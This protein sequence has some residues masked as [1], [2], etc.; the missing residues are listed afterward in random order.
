MRL[1]ARH[2]SQNLRY[3]VRFCNS[4]RKA[5]DHRTRQTELCPQGRGG[6]DVDANSV[7][8]SARE[9]G[10]KSVVV[11]SARSTE[12]AGSTTSRS[13][14]VR[15]WPRLPRPGR[16]CAMVAAR[17]YGFLPGRRSSAACCALKSRRP[18]NRTPTVRRI[19]RRV[20]VSL[21]SPPAGFPPPNLPDPNN[22]IIPLTTQGSRG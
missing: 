4:S 16:L 2:Q 18:L 3:F 22:R 17:S 14:R 19:I 6:G 5:S 21:P 12:T 20:Q 10:Q 15:K 1:P 8:S 9:E 11:L 7:L 13:A